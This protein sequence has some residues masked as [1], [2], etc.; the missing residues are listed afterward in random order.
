[1]N[2]QENMDGM[3]ENGWFNND[4]DDTGKSKSILLSK[5]DLSGTT[6]YGYLDNNKHKMQCNEITPASN[7]ELPELPDFFKNNYFIILVIALF[8]YN[9]FSYYLVYKFETKIMNSKNVI[10][11]IF[12]MNDIFDVA[13]SV[14][15]DIFGVYPHYFYN[16]NVNDSKPMLFVWVFW[17][18]L[19]F[20]YIFIF[21]TGTNFLPKYTEDAFGNDFSKNGYLF[22]LQFFVIFPCILFSIQIIRVHPF[23]SICLGIIIII[24]LWY[25]VLLIKN[26]LSM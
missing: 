14:L 20:C 19:I 24:N 17:L 15:K 6:T 18:F 1:M 21:Y 3:D 2:T 16:V 9:L 25:S 4:F 23:L 26:N 7:K 22:C 10:N 13:V 12:D 5:K 8:F 11:D